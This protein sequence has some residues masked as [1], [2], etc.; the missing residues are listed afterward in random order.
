MAGVVGK[1][2]NQG[3]LGGGRMALPG[4]GIHREFVP[5][6]RARLAVAAPDMTLPTDTQKGYDL[7]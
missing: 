6:P 7:H 1:T 5:H 3:L 4:N 2:V